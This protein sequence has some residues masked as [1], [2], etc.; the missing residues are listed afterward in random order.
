MN[1]FNNSMTILINN[2]INELTRQKH[3]LIRAIERK[4]VEKE[5]GDKKVKELDIEIRKLMHEFVDN[6]INNIKEEN[7]M[8]EEQ[9][10]ENGKEK[11]AKGTRQNSKST[12][13][14]DLLKKKSIKSMDALVAKA[15]ETIPNLEEK[16]FVNQ[17]RYFIAAIKKGKDK[18]VAGLDWDNES[19]TAVEKQ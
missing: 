6:E 10:K 8:V 4:E 9:K 14:I 13:I 17:V 7:K 18:R 1:G 12:L 3:D 15:K 5:E 11:K 16:K 19:F 2:K